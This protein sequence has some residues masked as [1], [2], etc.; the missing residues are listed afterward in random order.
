MKRMLAR[1][2][3]EVSEFFNIPLGRFAPHV[4]AAMIGCEK[5]ENGSKD[6]D[7]Q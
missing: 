1:W 3:W 4:F 6:H 2:L 7:S 5:Y